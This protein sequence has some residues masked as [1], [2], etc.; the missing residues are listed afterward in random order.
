MRT[1]A[2]QVPEDGVVLAPELVATWLP[3]FVHHPRLLGVRT[4]YL[5]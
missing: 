2:A 1:D 4:V 5:P 3:T